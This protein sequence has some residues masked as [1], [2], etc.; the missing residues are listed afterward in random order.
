MG[1][2]LAMLIGV[3]DYENEASLEPCSRDL[4]LMSSII[5]LTEKYDDCLILNNSPNSSSAKSDLSSFIRK[6]NDDNIEE[7]F[8]YYTGHGTRYGDDFL[9]LFSDFSSTKVE[10]TSLRNSELDSM[11][12]SLK[13]NLAVKIVDACQSGTEYIKSNNDLQVVFEKSSTNNFKKTYFLFSSSNTQSSI[14]LP[15]YSVFTKSFA[16]SL[17]S[18]NG[19]DIRFRDIMAYI[20]DDNAVQKYQTPL[21]VQ[22]ADNTE[23]FC[24]VSDLLSEKLEELLPVVQLTALPQGEES[25]VEG[26]KAELS[27]GEKLIM[28]IRDKAK[29]YCN[30]EECMQSLSKLFK[31]VQNFEW[32]V[33]F[34]ELYNVEVVVES[35][36][37]NLNNTESIANWIKSNNDNYFAR[38]T[39]KDEKYQDKEKV[40]YENKS[41]HIAAFSGEK[42]IEYRPVTRY[43][44]VIDGFVLTTPS[45]GT[46]LVVSL[47]PTE[48]NLP[49]YQVFVTFVFSKS[50]LTVFCKYERLKEMSW[51]NRELGNSQEWQIAHCKLCDHDEIQNVISSLLKQAESSIVNVLTKRFGE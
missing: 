33:I 38:V 49:W 23:V 15:D 18:F 41:L 12:K 34:N 43:R 16:R 40:V 22:Q 3:S 50:K 45:P 42:R 39:Y 11:L 14:A 17:Q 25:V 13:P 1:K 46:A 5:N 48:E 21:F 31:A 26:G 29:D 9:Y 44:K 10:Q 19:K 30:E 20:S 36:Y 6:Y 8:F 35:D 28:A 24:N 7:V 27:E 2:K 37:N 32:S 4:D 51:N 47:T